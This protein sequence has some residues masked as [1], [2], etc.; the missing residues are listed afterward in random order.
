VNACPA[1][2]S[3]I[4][5]LRSGTPA[6]PRDERL[7]NDQVAPGLQR[8]S[9][10]HR[11]IAFLLPALQHLKHPRIDRHQSRRIDGLY[12]IHSLPHDRSLDGKFAPQPVHVSPF[13]SKTLTYAQ[14]KTN[15]NQRNHDALPNQAAYRSGCHNLPCPAISFGE[16]RNYTNS[17]ILSVVG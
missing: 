10:L 4:W 3:L 17:Q 11:R 12:I 15:T 16:V 7:A 2:R 5:N 14:T 8:S 6:K 13:E 1:C 9:H